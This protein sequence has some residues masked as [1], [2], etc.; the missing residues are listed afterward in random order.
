MD[1]NIRSWFTVNTQTGEIYVSGGLDRETAVTVRLEISATDNA[2]SDFSGVTSDPNAKVTI[3]IS[4]END[5][6]PIFQPEGTTFILVQLQEGSPRGTIVIDVDAV[7]LDEGVNG[8]IN[9][10]LGDLD[11]NVFD[12]DQS[13]GVITVRNPIDREE[14]PW[15]NFT[16]GAVDGGGRTKVIPI[17]VEITDINDNNPMFDQE[18]FTGNVSENAEIG[19]EVVVITATDLDIGVFGNLTYVIRGGNVGNAF[20]IDPRTGVIYVN[21]PLDKETRSQYTLT[22]RASDNTGG[23]ASNRRESSVEVVIEVLDSNEFAPIVEPEISVTV[24]EGQPPDTLVGVIDAVD[25]DN[26]DQTLI[27][28]IVGTQPEDGDQLI[29]INETTGEIFTKDELDRDNSTYGDTI[30]INVQVSDGGN[31]AMISNT[32]ITV[33]IGDINDNSPFFPDGPYM[34]EVSEVAPVG[35]PVIVIVAEDLDLDSDLTYTIIGGNANDTFFIHPETGEIII[36]KP[37]DFETQPI[38][39]LVIQVEDEGGFTSTTT[40][41]IDISDAND[42]GPTFVFDVYEFQVQENSPEFHEVGLLAAIDSDRDGDIRY[43]IISGNDDNKFTIDRLTGAILVADNLDRE[44]RDGYTLIVEARDDT[45]PQYKDTALVT[46][47]VTDEN[48]ITPTF[49]ADEYTKRLQ[50]NTDV[51]SL[52][53][54]LPAQDG[55]LGEN[56]RVTYHIVS[57]NIGDTFQIEEST[58]AITVANP[59]T[60]LNPPVYEFDLEIEARDQGDPSLVGTTH[61]LITIGDTNDRAPTFIVPGRGE[62]LYLPENEE[63]GYNITRVIA[64]DGDTGVNGNVTYSIDQ[65]NMLFYIDPVTG[66][67]YANFSA[68]RETKSEY[69]LILLASDGGEPPRTTHY[70]VTI[71][72]TDKDDN[73][74]FF[75][76]LDPQEPTPQDLEVEEHSNS[77][78]LVGAVIPAV[79]LDLGDNAVIYYCIVEG[80]EN[81]QFAI[82]RDSGNITVIGDLDRETTP[83]IS[84]LVLATNDSS[85]IS[86]GPYDP[87]VNNNLKEVKIHLT[88]I[89]DNG[90]MFLKLSML[91]VCHWMQTLVS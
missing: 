13:S 8:Q 52:V 54:L 72:I 88:D 16:I 36:T 20:R 12:L 46:I 87:R 85:C 28:V 70:E 67:L 15:V 40:L 27:F 32:T 39:N 83:T 5:N 18:Q 60:S 73:L 26:P 14:L 41:Q 82:D 58:G 19:T 49:T 10:Y 43:F 59:I 77:S 76:R 89:N 64:I 90:P 78:T 6:D 80:N 17:Y 21:R 51:E 9:Y 69:N 56:G 68:D 84:L 31:P 4:D 3:H 42:Q 71:R 61:V 34:R 48:D 86:S 44:M 91:Q 2:V 75:E 7:D 24:P 50:E 30:I 66:D 81:N 22:V 62:I 23:L 1:D 63:A 33:N 25:P 79:D 35:S 74:P 55:D 11:Y 37:L 53:I 65:D 38:Y 57:G 45:A 47:E 29:Y